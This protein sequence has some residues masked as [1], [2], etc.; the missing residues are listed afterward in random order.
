MSHLDFSKT[1]IQIG[2]QNQHLSKLLFIF[3]RYHDLL[4]ND[5]DITHRLNFDTTTQQACIDFTNQLMYMDDEQL[6]KYIEENVP[7]E[8]LPFFVNV[9]YCALK[10]MYEE[11]IHDTSRIQVTIQTAYAL[12]DEQVNQIVEV[13]QAKEGKPCYAN[14]EVNPKIIGGLCV[15]YNTK[16]FD[17]TYATKLTKMKQNIIKE[18]NQDEQEPNK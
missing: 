1:P 8:K 15:S 5:E 12:T 17:D 18:I 11:H 6:N 7:V 9:V 16:I 13:I 14:V 10:L 3:K 4:E 2:S